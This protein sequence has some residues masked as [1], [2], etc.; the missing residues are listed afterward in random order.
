RDADC[1]RQLADGRVTR[2]RVR[3]RSLMLQDR[4]VD[5]LLRRHPPRVPD[6]IP[7]TAALVDVALPYRLLYRCGTCGERARVHGIDGRHVYVKVHGCCRPLGESLREHADGVPDTDLGVPDLPLTV[8]ATKLLCVERL[9][10]E[11]D[12]LL[13][14]IDDQ[15][16]RNRRVPLWLP[17]HCVCHSVPPGS[18]EI[19]RAVVHL[20][21]LRPVVDRLPLRFVHAQLAEAPPDDADRTILA[22]EPPLDQQ[23]RCVAHDLPVRSIQVS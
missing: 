5:F 22:L 21:D 11:V 15:V 14:A 20:L 9:S 6:R 1:A 17:I 4:R 8:E 19:P 3:P 16:R 18:M 23:E 2:A 13:C 12:Q 7:E 10:Q